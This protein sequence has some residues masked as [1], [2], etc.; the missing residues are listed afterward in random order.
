MEEAE[1][2]LATYPPKI[3]EAFASLSVASPIIAA[4][5][6]GGAVDVGIWNAAIGR[7]LDF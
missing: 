7:E 6:T 2:A 3:R 4:H 5:P 1:T